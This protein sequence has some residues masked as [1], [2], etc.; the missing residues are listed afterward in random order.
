VLG[1]E[2]PPVGAEPDGPALVTAVWPTQLE[3]A[4]TPL[5][6]E[7]KSHVAEFTYSRPEW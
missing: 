2:D 5:S 7:I 3:F 4:G 6:S 1:P